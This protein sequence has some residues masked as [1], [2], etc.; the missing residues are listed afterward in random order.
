MKVRKSIYID[1]NLW[2]YLS[3]CAALNNRSENQFITMLLKEFV[4]ADILRGK[5]EEKVDE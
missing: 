4:D 5:E 3:E 1:A 2:E